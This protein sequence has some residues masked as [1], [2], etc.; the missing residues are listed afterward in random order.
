MYNGS[1]LGATYNYKLIVQYFGRLL[2]YYYKLLINAMSWIR[3]IGFY[4]LTKQ[5]IQTIRNNQLQEQLKLYLYMTLTL[6]TT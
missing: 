1:S 4:I 6:G 5:L 2:R 3:I